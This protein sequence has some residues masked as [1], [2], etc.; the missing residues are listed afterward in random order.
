MVAWTLGLMIIHPALIDYIGNSLQIQVKN[1]QVT[2]TL[3]VG[4]F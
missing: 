1:L 4:E 2:V 3:T